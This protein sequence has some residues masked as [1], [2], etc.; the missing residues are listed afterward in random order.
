MYITLKQLRYFNALA[1]FR[2][3]GKAAEHCAVSQP[4][5][6]MQI[7]D[8]ETALGA[9]LVERRS[10]GIV[11]TDHGREVA[12]R[13]KTVLGELRDLVDYAKHA[14]RLLSG[15]LRLGL[16]PS[17]AP[18]L[19]PPL[20]PR[21]RE[22]Y[23]DLQLEVRETQT[24][25][26]LAELEEHRLDA[27]IIALPVQQPNIDSLRLFEDRLVLAIPPGR[28]TAGRK[29][30]SASELIGHEQLLL[31][32][33]GHCLREQALSFCRQQKVETV[34]T[35]GTSSLSTIVRMVANGHG[36]TL[37]PEISIHM[38]VRAG[39]VDLIRFKK[40]QPLRVL[41]LAWRSS[42]P[43][44]Q[45]FAELGQLITQLHRELPLAS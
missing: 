12:R 8:L 7:Q 14:N 3:F 15:K 41:A 16:I 20:L 28:N 44:K 4:A 11:L 27:I 1:E 36:V 6:S 38:E 9:I 17:V 32:E 18:Y 33:E 26:L 35:F 13:A 42:S 39:E 21:L 45:D 22:N 23:P 29:T 25:T 43:R 30:K 5:L 37:L 40:P 34:Y 2:H 24:A 10:S 31:L 19:L